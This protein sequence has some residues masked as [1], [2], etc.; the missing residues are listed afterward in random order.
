MR[1]I[2]CSDSHGRAD[3]LQQAV[4]RY[5]VDVI[6]HLGDHRWDIEKI[7]LP[8][9]VQVV[10][11]QGNCDSL[12][13][14]EKLL[15]LEGKKVFI[16]HGHR[17]GVKSSLTALKLRMK[18][19]GADIVLYGHTHVPGYEFYGSGLLVNP[20]ALCGNRTNRQ[21]GFA[22]LEWKNGGQVYIQMTEV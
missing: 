4:T 21:A 15:E 14:D 6:V 7:D 1:V 17:Y 22:Y 16:T 11:V 18:E 9:G 13:A 12:Q 19:L 3:L 8:D 5:P 2:V 20:G 10:A